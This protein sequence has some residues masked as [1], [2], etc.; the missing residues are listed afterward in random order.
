[1]TLSGPFDCIPNVL[2]QLNS[3]YLPPTKE[4]KLEQTCPADL[5]L[6]PKAFCPSNN[7][8]LISRCFQRKEI[9]TYLGNILFV[10]ITAAC[11]LFVQVSRKLLLYGGEYN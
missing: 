10:I 7:Q 1:M 11:K 2:C 3:Q 8:C 4:R 6:L 9:Q 5:I